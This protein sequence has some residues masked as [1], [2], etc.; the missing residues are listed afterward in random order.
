M[1]AYFLPDTV[2]IHLPCGI[3]GAYFVAAWYESW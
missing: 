1:I 2:Y 3:D